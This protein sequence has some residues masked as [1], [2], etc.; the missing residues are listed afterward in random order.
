VVQRIRVE[1][2][3][4]TERQG[5][6]DQGRDVPPTGFLDLAAPAAPELVDPKAEARAKAAQALKSVVPVQPILAPVETIE[7][8]Q[9]EVAE[10]ERPEKTTDLKVGARGTCQHCGWDLTRASP[11][12]PSKADMQ[13]FLRSV[14]GG[15]VYTKAL[16]LF[17]GAARVTFRTRTE[18][19]DEGVRDALRYL[20][21]ANKI[22]NDRDLVARARRIHLAVGIET[23]TLGTTVI[24]FVNLAEKLSDKIRDGEAVL[25]EVDSRLNRIPTQLLNAL[26]GAF[27]EFVEQAELMTSRAQDPGF[28]IGSVP[29]L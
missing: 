24:A 2:L 27:D 5:L 1:D 13:D 7:A 18:L 15:E 26:Y 11:P 21:R 28:W 4:P 14:M 19:E 25:N 23:L 12:E 16:Q 3:T 20:I 29:T 22:E 8:P 6:K 9:P 10:A 17:G